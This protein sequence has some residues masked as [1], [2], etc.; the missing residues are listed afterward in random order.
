MKKYKLKNGNKIPALG[1][2]T[3]KLVGQDCLDSVLK[4]LELGYRHIDTADKYGNHRHVGEAI[5]QSRIDRKEIFLTTKGWYTD[6]RTEDLKN[7]VNRFL[8][9]L[10]T[11][12][13]D[14]LLIHWPNRNIPL[15]ES[16]EA[17][18]Q[19]KDKGIIKNIG[20]SN[21]TVNHLKDCLKT[22]I[23][24]V[25]NQVEI[26]PTFAQFELQKF[27]QENGIRLTAYSPL[28]RGADL[29]IPELLEIAQKHNKSVPQVIINWLI[30]RGIITIPKA[31]GEEHIRQNFEAMDF[32]LFSEDI[33][34][35]NNLDKG[36]RLIDNEWSEFDY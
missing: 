4:A 33:K 13:L 30:S 25:N 24:V 3:W 32:E 27:A 20:V 28:G 11:D 26:H 8:E 34:V 9:E 10:E 6:L 7:A 22:G 2:G 18:N 1:F 21:F 16:L 23:E 14:L 35:I 19:L 12:Y 5:H 17:M 15:V 29:Q 36:D 31:T